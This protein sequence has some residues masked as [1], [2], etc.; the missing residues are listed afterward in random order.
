MPFLSGLTSSII[1]LVCGSGVDSLELNPLFESVA[2]PFPLSIG[3]VATGDITCPDID[4]V[5]RGLIDVVI[6]LFL[7]ASLFFLESNS[8]STFTTASSILS[9][10]KPVV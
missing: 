8:C 10:A 2:L 9:F 5:F 7:S 6:V 4:G 1:M 3:D